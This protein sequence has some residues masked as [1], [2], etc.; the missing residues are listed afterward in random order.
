MKIELE[1]YQEILD[2]FLK[3]PTAH[4]TLKDLG[5]DE[6]D[7]V[8]DTEN[9]IFHM[10]LLVENGL[11]SNINMETGTMK[12]IGLLLSRGRYDGYIAVPIRLTQDGHDFANALNEKPILDILKKEFKNAPFSFMKTTSKTLLTKYLEKKLDKFLS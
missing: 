6:L 2:V 5:I 11:I 12:S 3:S 9:F 1:E 7:T 8:E 4:I 10:Q